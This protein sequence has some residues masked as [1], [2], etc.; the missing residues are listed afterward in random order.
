M[1]LEVTPATSDEVAWERRQTKW[2]AGWRRFV[3]P[4]ILLA[5]LIYVLDASS[6]HVHGGTLALA[7]AI[8]AVFGA[9]YL[10]L[11]LQG[12][13]VSPRR[14]WIPYGVL[15]LLFVAELP[16][17]RATGFVLCVYLTILAVA[18]NGARSTPLV[19]LYT[20][21]S[22]VVPLLISSWHDS[23]GKVFGDV[24]PLAIPIVALASFSVV[25]VQRGNI[26]LADARAEQAR[27]AAENERFRI[28]RDLHDL[29]GHSLTAITVKAGLARRLGETDPARAL[30]EIAEVEALARRSL[31][32]VRAAIS[33]YR[34]VTL[35]GELIN[36][37][38]LLRAAGIAADL[39]RALEVVNPVEQE[40]FGWV[41]REGLTNVVRHAHASSC[42]VRLSATSVEIVDNGIG[43]S[44]PAGN[45][46][47]GLRER[48][49]AAGGSVDAGPL[50]TGGWRLA[51]TLAPTQ[52]HQ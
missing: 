50:D 49:A 34:E 31:A 52:I 27:L 26:A 1:E 40:L 36:G 19:A 29:L 4:A 32:D 18:R 45:G 9:G 8:T 25:Q 47:S 20:A 23:I 38:E 24:T 22:I 16:F 6:T 13:D 51:V 2:G 41:V 42:V 21:G 14:F 33:N 10:A 35:A 5:Y 3:F 44:N 46:L 15:V 43:G 37:R 39:P 48:V 30:K 11:H 12:Y 17:A 28:A 7:D